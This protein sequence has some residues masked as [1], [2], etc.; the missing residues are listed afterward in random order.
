MPVRSRIRT[1][2]AIPVLAWG[3]CLASLAVA[4]ARAEPAGEASLRAAPTW[5]EQPRR[6]LVDR[7]RA[8]APAC[9]IAQALFDAAPSAPAEVGP[10]KSQ[11]LACR[12]DLGK[13]RLDESLPFASPDVVYGDL[14]AA[15]GVSPSRRR[16]PARVALGEGP[17]DANRVTVLVPKL[18]LSPGQVVWLRVV[19]RD[20]QF[21]DLVAVLKV[22][23]E[24]SLPLSSET[25]AV[26]GSCRLVPPEAIEAAVTDVLARADERLELTRTKARAEVASSAGKGVD[27][28]LFPL[29]EQ[30]GQAAALVGWHDPRVSTRVR[31][32]DALAAE[33]TTTFGQRFDE[34]RAQAV[35]REWTKL[36]DDQLELR[37]ERV[38]CGRKHLGPYRAVFSFFG[39]L[40]KDVCV[41]VLGARN[42]TDRPVLVDYNTIGPLDDL[43]VVDRRG[44]RA[45]E[46][47][48]G[49]M[50][51]RRARKLRGR[52]ELTLKPGAQVS[53]VIAPLLTDEVLRTPRL[54]LL[55]VGQHEATITGL[56]PSAPTPMDRGRVRVRLADLDC[57]R[58]DLEQMA[59]EAWVFKHR[60]PV[61]SLV[62]T[63]ENTGPKP[64]DLAAWVRGLSLQDLT[65][66]AH[67]VVG[68]LLPGP[69]PKRQRE[70]VKV[71]PGETGSL[72]LLVSKFHG[73]IEDLRIANQVGPYPVFIEIQS[74]D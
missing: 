57:E 17:E 19:D 43:V 50:Q 46:H 64:I 70:P 6:K 30:L 45:V 29:R 25:P 74:S 65:G 40:G 18:D 63:L 55:M 2:V 8:Y 38:V 44:Q 28:W 1:R 20:V 11:A 3:L 5:F 58:A 61:C 33:L 12:L 51:G 39:R 59:E 42:L 15:V 60:R 71:A 69:V 7:A 47:I 72:I 34:A 21:D 31:A 53:V 66:K 13:R 73:K 36:A 62:L 26:K 27:D 10:L 24:G 14:S 56:N 41:I 22:P 4:G 37:V 48:Q 52:G 68:K 54:P 49:R 16:S 35:G 32:A 67:K 23:Y 9:P